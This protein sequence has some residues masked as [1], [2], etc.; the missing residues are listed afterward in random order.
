[1]APLICLSE[2]YLVVVVNQ[3]NVCVEDDVLLLM[4]CR[5][6]IQIA[7]CFERLLHPGDCVV[8]DVCVLL[9]ANSLHDTV[10]VSPLSNHYIATTCYCPR[11]YS[12]H[13]KYFGAI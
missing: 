12:I 1:M 3:E 13:T 6:Y 7:Y 11:M 5:T 9:S 8:H 2:T 10:N 4:S